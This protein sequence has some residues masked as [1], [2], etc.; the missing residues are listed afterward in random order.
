MITKK[1]LLAAAAAVP[2]LAFAAPAQAQ[3]SGIASANPVVAMGNSK[4]FSAA[5][6]QIATMYKSN[7]D[8]ADAKEKSRQALLVQLDKNGDKNLDQAELDAAI[9]AKSPLLT[10]AETAEREIATLSEPAVRAQA[11]S[12]ENMLKGY[13][14]ALRKVV[15]D[16][17]ISVVLSPE[18][19]VFAPPTVDVT[20][21]ITA[22]MDKTPAGAV[23]APP[24]GWNPSRQTVA[25]MQ[26]LQQFQQYQVARAYAAQQR[27][28][29][30]NPAAGQQRPAG[31]PA[32]APATAR[33]ANPTQP[34]S[35]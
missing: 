22:E 31:T 28:A 27:A 35:R 32:P 18:S 25:L 3:V 33:P 19:F 26:Q 21:A 23:T 12:I 7:L 5:N 4:A 10:Q 24:S 29:A 6:Q 16:K 34:Q 20:D 15:T 17:R 11:Y 30:A 1:M 2:V 14:T 13:D 9:A 8:Q